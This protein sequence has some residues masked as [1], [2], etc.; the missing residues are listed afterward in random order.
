MLKTSPT[1][2]VS[3]LGT[4]RAG[5]C[6]RIWIEGNRLIVAGFLP[7]QKFVKAYVDGR[8]V[9]TTISDAAFEKLPTA[10]RGTVSGKGIKPII[11]VVGQAVIETFQPATHVA[12]TYKVGQIIIKRIEGKL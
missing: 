5:E 2:F 4:T 9:L 6:S 3:K 10:E 11:D 7:G 8:L 12:V 1:T